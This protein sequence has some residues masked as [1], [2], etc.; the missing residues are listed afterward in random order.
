MV[1]GG[2]TRNSSEKR[3]QMLCCSATYWEIKEPVDSLFRIKLEKKESFISSRNATLVVF[4]AF[5]T[6]NAPAKE[7]LITM[8]NHKNVYH[9]K[10]MTIP[11]NSN[12][13]SQNIRI[14]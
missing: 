12:L 4:S 2:T 5:T 9:R 11:Q 6:L 3:N 7:Q 1:E 8:K 10:K 14:C 13:K